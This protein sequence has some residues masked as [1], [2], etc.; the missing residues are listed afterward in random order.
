MRSQSLELMKQ[1]GDW[2]INSQLHLLQLIIKT[3]GIMELS[4]FD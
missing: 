3:K 4:V 2:L 1:K